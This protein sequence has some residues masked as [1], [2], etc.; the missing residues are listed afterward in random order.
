MSFYD[1]EGY[2]Q[3]FN[4]SCECELPD[5]NDATQD[6]NCAECL[7]L[8]EICDVYFGCPVNGITALPITGYQAGAPLT[9]DETINATAIAAWESANVAA[10]GADKIRK[11]EVLGSSSSSAG[12][13]IR[14][15]KNKKFPAQKTITYTLRFFP[16]CQ[17]D[18]DFLR[19]LEC[20]GQLSFWYGTLGEGF[21]GGMNGITVSIIDVQLN[22]AEGEEA[23]NEGVLV[24]EYKTKQSPNRD[25]YQA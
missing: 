2:P 17:K 9:A 5:G 20:G 6:E 8:S 14:G 19:A 10:T 12:T 7:E 22:H 13:A 23:Y 24:L 25:L 4:E 11:F 3:L 21:Y 16:L 15:S 1:A 18:R